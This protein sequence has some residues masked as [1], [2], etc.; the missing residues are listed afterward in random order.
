VIGK[1]Q[2]NSVSCYGIHGVL[3]I[4][5]TKSQEFR[6]DVQLCGDFDFKTG[7]DSLD[8]TLDYSLVVN[9][10]EDVIKGPHCS[11]IE[12]L[13]HKI[14]TK[15]E[16]SVILNKV[17]INEIKI[18]VTKVNPP[19]ETIQN[20]SFEL[21]YKIKREAYLSLGSNL[22]NRLNFLKTACNLLPSI[23]DISSVYQTKPEGE[24][25]STQ[26]DYLNCVV[27]IETDILPLDLLDICH[28]IEKHAGRQRYFRNSARTLDVDIL[29]YGDLTLNDSL[30]TVPH[31]RMYHRAF[32]IEPLLEIVS[33]PSSIVPLTRTETYKK[34]CNNVQKLGKL[35]L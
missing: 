10:V 28:D 17:L 25:T 9:I 34:S 13:A 20:V 29:I 32:V 16:E 3:D 26:G 4:E 12:T 22:F 2:I 7:T 1:I 31:P 18:K 35:I 11:L 27:R 8:D 21:L 24:N 33:D 30:L 14:A 19:I 15:I 6:V 5:K 23:T